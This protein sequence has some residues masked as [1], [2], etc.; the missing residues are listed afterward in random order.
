MKRT[1]CLL[2]LVVLAVVPSTLFA[3]PPLELLYDEIKSDDSQKFYTMWDFDHGV[4]LSRRLFEPTEMFG[5]NK[6]R[7][8]G[9]IRVCNGRFVEHGKFVSLIFAE[10]P[11]TQQLIPACEVNRLVEFTTTN[12]GFKPVWSNRHASTRIGFFGDSFTEGL[13]VAPSKTFASLVAQQLDTGAVNFGVNGYSTLEMQ[14]C[15]EQFAEQHRLT[16]AA[17]FLFPND[18]HAYYG[19]VLKNPTLFK[20]E[21]QEVFAHIL[22]INTY[23]TQRGIQPIYIV[24]PCKEQFPTRTSSAFYRYLQRWGDAHEITF[25]D[26]K[27]AFQNA[28][29]FFD[30]DP[31][32]N[33][34]GH[35]GFAEWLLSLP[36]WKK[37]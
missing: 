21:F 16:H 22:A 10:T 12:D 37:F 1:C 8:K 27:E 11:R 9:N 6:Y 29:N 19:D 30:W 15:L 32:F 36:V 4:H 14:W 28:D 2:I 34:Q 26:G 13:W 5:Q 20:G 24:V 33:E 23:C 35:Q 7:Y 18:V 17:F 25:Y 31:H 3:K